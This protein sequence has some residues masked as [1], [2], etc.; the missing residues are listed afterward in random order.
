MTSWCPIAWPVVC[1]VVVG[2]LITPPQDPL[3]SWGF[4]PVMVV[5]RSHGSLWGPGVVSVTAMT[6]SGTRVVVLCEGDELEHSCTANI[7]VW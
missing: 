4:P 6:A 7:I 2:P 5:G 3:Q 1:G